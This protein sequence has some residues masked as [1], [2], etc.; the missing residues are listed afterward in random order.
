MGQAV[1][2]V[3]SGA[4]QMIFISYS[5]KDEVVAGKVCAG[6]EEKGLN[7]WIAPRDIPAGGSYA[8]AIMRGLAESK[9]M[10]IIITED[11]VLSEHVKNEVEHAFSSKVPIIPMRVSNIDPAA[12]D[13][14]S[15]MKYF[16]N[17]MQWFDAASGDMKA[18]IDGLAGQI[19]GLLSGQPVQ[20]QTQPIKPSKKVKNVSSIKI[21]AGL[22]IVTALAVGAYVAVQP[23]GPAPVDWQKYAVANELKMAVPNQQIEVTVKTLPEQDI[24]HEGDKVILSVSVDKPAWIVAVLYVGS[25]TSILLYPNDFSDMRKLAAG[26]TVQLGAEGSG[27]DFT[28]SPPFGT[29]LVQVIASDRK[30]E[31]MALLGDSAAIEGTVLRSITAKALRETIGR[32]NLRS[33]TIGAKETEI[34]EG[35]GHGSVTITSQEKDD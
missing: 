30:E 12:L 19:N 16:L 2:S 24:Y 17:R 29:D 5:T 15:D 10:V 6:L 9:V 20:H 21:L 25:D 8:S 14:T 3:A 26:E 18:H 27:F 34:T 11:S 33:I 23:A 13:P 35:W 1:Q 32:V 28:I 31:L 7:C 4:V 22:L